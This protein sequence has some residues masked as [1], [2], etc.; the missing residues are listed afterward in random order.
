VTIVRPALHD[1]I[2]PAARTNA[3]APPMGITA[4][5]FHAYRSHGP[6]AGH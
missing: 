6:L 5:T 1:G 2:G 4:K 3:L